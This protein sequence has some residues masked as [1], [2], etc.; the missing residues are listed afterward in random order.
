[1]TDP[2][3]RLGA[4][5]CEAIGEG[6]LAQPAAAISSLA[7]VGAAAWLL[8][9]LPPD[10]PDRGLAAT[11][12]GLVAL[13]G[14]GSVAYHGPQ[15]AG[16]ELAHDVPILLA[17]LTGVAVPVARRLRGRPALGRGGTAAAATA[18]AALAVGVASYVLG[19]SGGPLCDPESLLQPHAVWHVATAVAAAAWGAA[20]WRD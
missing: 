6:V 3:R 1:M 17:G 11:Y 4:S 15:P 19:R 20:L 14:V 12:A 2:R 5:D 18:G 7:F 9:R 16:A 10:Q 13:V 8:R